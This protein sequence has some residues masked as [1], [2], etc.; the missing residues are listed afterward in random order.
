[1][2]RRE[3]PVDPG[4]GPVSR[5]AFALRKLRDE[6]GGM[7][8]RVMARRTGYSVPTLS[9]AAGG[10]SLPSLP[11]TLAYVK[12][13][14]GDEGEWEERWRQAS[15]EA[16]GLAAAE[17]GGAAPYQGLARFDTGDRE[18]FFGREKL[19]GELVEV[20]RRSRFTAVVGASGSG[21]SSLLRAGLV[22]A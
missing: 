7:T 1:M 3:S 11:V 18:R 12:A 4:A 16:A 17:E 13:C 22:P 20:V 6:A 2:P 10:E 14:G 8:Y 15:E 5:F 21:K 19:V 9:R